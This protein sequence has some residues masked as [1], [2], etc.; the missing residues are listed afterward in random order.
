QR[1]RLLSLTA[2]GFAVMYA[3][4]C[5]AN[6]VLQFSF[7]RQ[8]LASGNLAGLEP[9]TSASPNSALFVT[10]NLGFFL[11]GIATLALAPL[12]GGSRLMNAIKWLFI[13]NGVST[14]A[15]LVLISVSS[16]AS[17]SGQALYTVTVLVWGI[18]LAV[19]LLLLAVAFRRRLLLGFHDRKA[20]Q[21]AAQ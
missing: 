4:I 16:L 2:F 19:A 20:P 1:W 17:P 7:V 15:G 11:Q 12:F 8:Q 13:L 9:W 3:A 14:A 6:C 21:P 10:D 5:S 18:V